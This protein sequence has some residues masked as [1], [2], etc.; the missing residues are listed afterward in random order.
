MGPSASWPG[1]L[2]ADAG[3]ERG[4][5]GVGGEGHDAGDRLVE[6]ERQRVDIGAS[7]DTVAEGLFGRRIPGRADR[8]PGRLGQRRLGQGARQAEV[9]DAQA[10]LVVEE[11]V[12]GLDVAVDEAPGVRVGEPLRRL[13]APTDSAWETLRRSPSSSMSRSDPPPRNSST[14]NG[15]WSSSPQSCTASTLACARAAADCASARKRRRKPLSAARAGCRTL[16]A[17]RRCRVVS[18]AANTFADAPLPSADFD[19][20]AA[21]KDPTDGFGDRRHGSDPGYRRPPAPPVDGTTGRG[22]REPRDVRTRGARP[23]SR[24]ASN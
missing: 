12:G 1:M 19:P 8:H 5:G 18:N 14:R 11:E 21:G 23:V 22:R 13:R 6:H 10:G 17:T 24:R 9:G 20:V 16:T 7:V 3:H 4:D 15:P 2:G